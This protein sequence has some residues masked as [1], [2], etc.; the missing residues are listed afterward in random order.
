MGPRGQHLLLELEN[1]QVPAQS[2]SVAS[3]RS[4]LDDYL[5]LWPALGRQE[6]IFLPPPDS[7]L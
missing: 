3:W 5:L 7:D 1:E 6:D 2:L 4:S